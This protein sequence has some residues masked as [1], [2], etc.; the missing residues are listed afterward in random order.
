MVNIDTEKDDLKPLKLI[1]K[2]NVLVPVFFGE[3]YRYGQVIL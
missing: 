2:D 1:E 3:V